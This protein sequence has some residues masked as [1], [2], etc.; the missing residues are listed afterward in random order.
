MLTLLLEAGF[1]LLCS[2]LPPGKEVLKGGLGSSI[3]KVNLGSPRTVLLY[4][5]TEIP[6]PERGPFPNIYTYIKFGVTGSSQGVTAL[7]ASFQRAQALFYSLV[8]LSPF[9]SH[10]GL[11]FCKASSLVWTVFS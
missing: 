7:P 11:A 6:L 1:S 4:Y 3:H 10:M 9:G 8:Y 2:G 5:F